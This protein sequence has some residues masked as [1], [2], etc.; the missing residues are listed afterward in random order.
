MECYYRNHLNS[1]F[2]GEFFSAE[3]LLDT[4]INR[5]MNTTPRD[6]CSV[7]TCGA[8]QVAYSLDANESESEWELRLFDG[9]GEISRE[10]A[11]GMLN[12]QFGFAQ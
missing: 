5:T 11:I 12:R 6:F 2:S 4:L 7:Y 1:E 3:E 10:W 9:D 8:L